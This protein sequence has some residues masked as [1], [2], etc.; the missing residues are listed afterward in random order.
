MMIVSVLGGVIYLRGRFPDDQLGDRLELKCESAVL[1]IGRH[2]LIILN[3]SQNRSGAVIRFAA[4]LPNVTVLFALL[5]G[6]RVQLLIGIEQS[7][8]LFDIPFPELDA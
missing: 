1:R 6:N 5:R 3:G 2:W 7:G 8:L 4:D